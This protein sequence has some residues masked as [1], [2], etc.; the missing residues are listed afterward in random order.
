MSGNEAGAL[1][2][3]GLT[4]GALLSALLTT[5]I[6]SNSYKSYLINHGY[7]LYCPTDGHFAFNGK[8]NK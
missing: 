7:A 4:M 2:T 6:V 3:F 5:A 1:F 8:C